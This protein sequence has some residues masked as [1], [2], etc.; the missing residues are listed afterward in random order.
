MASAL[1]TSPF[2]LTDTLSL[3]ADL[4]SSPLQGR[5]GERGGF[6]LD[7]HRK[8]GLEMITLNFSLTARLITLL[9]LS[10]IFPVTHTVPRAVPT[11]PLS[12]SL[13][14]AAPAFKSYNRALSADLI[15]ISLSHK[16]YFRLSSFVL[17]G[18]NLLEGKYLHPSKS[19]TLPAS[20]IM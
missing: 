11:A 20:L 8:G 9:Q 5:A 3:P 18:M 7:F 12:L 13:G 6:R 1:D 4:Y 17:I 16:T 14:T 2:T 10:H 19:P 15:E